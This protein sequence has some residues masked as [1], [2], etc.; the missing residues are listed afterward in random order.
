MRYFVYLLYLMSNI[1][2]N[3]ISLYRKNKKKDPKDMFPSSKA[4]KN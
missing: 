2:Y 4:A 3:I 1:K